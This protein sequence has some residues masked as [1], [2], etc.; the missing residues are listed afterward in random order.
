M[1]FS[2]LRFN[3]RSLVFIG[4]LLIV[5]FFLIGIRIGKKIQQIDSKKIV[6]SPIQNPKIVFTALKLKKFIASACGFQFLYPAEFEESENATNEASLI[7]KANPQNNTTNII[8]ISC[9][10][11]SKMKEFTDKKK[12]LKTEGIRV[13]DTID[14]NL[15][16][17]DITNTA[18]VYFIHPTSDKQILM[19]IPHSLLNLFE[20]TLKFL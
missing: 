3:S 4:I 16:Q 20:S 12:Q 7:Y 8:T 10:S 11:P 14:I 2:P 5:F 15:Y 6:A 9:D 18:Y 19:R 1:L 13:V 17:S